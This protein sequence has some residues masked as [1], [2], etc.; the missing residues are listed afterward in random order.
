MFRR[1]ITGIQSPF[2]PAV[3]EGTGNAYINLISVDE[4]E[5]GILFGN[6][7][8]F[9]SGGIVYNN[10][11]TQ[12]NAMQFRTNGNQT[13]MTLS[14]LGFLGIGTLTPGFILDINDR[15][16]IRSGGNLSTTAGVWMNKTNNLE[17]QSFF[18]IE[19]DSYA[20]IYGNVS[21]WSFG[22]NTT[23]GDIKMMGR[24]GIGTTTPNAPL[25]FPPSLGKKITLYPGLTGDV[26]FAVAGNRLQIYSDNPNADV[27]IGYD[28]AGTFVERFSVKPNG[29]LALNT[30]TGLPGQ[31]LQSNGGGS[32]VSWT[33]PTNILYSSTEM[34]RL[35]TT[36]ITG[37]GNPAV[38]IP[39]LDYTFNISGNAKALVSFTLEGSSQCCVFCG[40]ST[41]HIDLYLDG[42]L[43]IRYR[44]DVGNNTITELNGRFM[45]S[46]N[47]GQHNIHLKASSFGPA[48]QYINGATIASNMI[49]Q[50]IPQ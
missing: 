38:I 21:G 10:A 24:V 44:W 17:L 4:F 22:M 27:A 33:S 41:A 45:F 42:N 47:P 35:N 18:G 15:M 11:S 3:I 8:D 28:A 14:S 16:R 26:G 43:A 36:L 29:A 39:G 2:S 5:T 40:N 48:M 1:A 46:L 6:G 32:S 37:E 9:A 30:N 49:V 50:V 23:N 31:V 7:T 13:R 19:N 34:L 25:S 20:G 12:M